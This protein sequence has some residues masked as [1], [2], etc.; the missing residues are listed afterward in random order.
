[1]FFIS[2]NVHRTVGPSAFLKLISILNGLVNI[3]FARH[4]IALA[5]GDLNVFRSKSNDEPS[6]STHSHVSTS[7]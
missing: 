5:R 3:F 1:M 7:F 2:L 4:F 6:V